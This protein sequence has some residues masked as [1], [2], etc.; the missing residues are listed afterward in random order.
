MMLGKIRKI[1]DRIFF[2]DS[3]NLELDTSSSIQKSLED[4]NQEIL[5]EFD[6]IEGKIRGK[7]YDPGTVN[8]DSANYLYKII[9][10]NSPDT[11]VETGVCNGVSTYAVLRA[12]EEESKGNL[13]SIDLPEKVDEQDIE[14]W[15]G[16]GG[17]VI[18]P[19]KESGW[20]IPD[21]LRNR[22]SFIEGDS[23]FRLPE[24]LEDKENIDIFIHDSEHSYQTMML[25]FC[26]AWKKLKEGGLLIC[27]DWTWNSA[28]RDFAKSQEC[29]KI[30]AKD[31]A[32]LRKEDGRK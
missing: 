1:T 19:G 4:K 27:D 14:H 6:K 23:N 20:I 7:D 10:E 17:A 24:V 13:T 15:S 8:L 31:F 5:R 30:K 12:L 25:E 16:K 11:V 29:T 28:F 9:R 21:N 22:W 32:I 18:P 2:W 3:E 26:I